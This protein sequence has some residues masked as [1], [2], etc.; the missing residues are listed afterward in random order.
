MNFHGHHPNQACLLLLLLRVF[1]SSPSMC[2]EASALIFG[3]KTTLPLPVYTLTS[4]SMVCKHLSGSLRSSKLS[5]YSSSSF[6]ELSRYACAR[7]SWTRNKNKKVFDVLHAGYRSVI[8]ARVL[9]PAHRSIWISNRL[10]T[11]AGIFLNTAPGGRG[12]RQLLEVTHVGVQQRVASPPPCHPPTTTTTTTNYTR[13]RSLARSLSCRLHCREV[14]SSDVGR[15]VF[16]GLNNPRFRELGY[17]ATPKERTSGSPS[18]GTQPS[19]SKTLRFHLLEKNIPTQKKPAVPV[20]SKN[21]KDGSGSMKEPAVS[22]LG[23]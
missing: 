23:S 18:S 6:G 4:F 9:P 16:D 21:L 13:A 7:A 1:S 10:Q 5:S 2:S 15:R 20:I 3:P 17:P 11:A 22:F 19:E 14:L 8:A 12:M